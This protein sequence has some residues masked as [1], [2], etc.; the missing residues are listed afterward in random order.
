MEVVLKRG[1][2]LALLLSLPGASTLAQSPP[3]NVPSPVSQ[4][5]TA[6]TL[7][8]PPQAAAAPVALLVDLGSGR[9]H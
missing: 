4:A 1:L 3:A 2:I 8:A 7:A 9:I 5:Q 6:V